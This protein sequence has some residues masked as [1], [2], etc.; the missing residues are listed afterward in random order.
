MTQEEAD[1]LRMLIEKTI[2]THALLDEARYSDTKASE[3][4]RE[5]INSLITRPK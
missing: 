5:Y 3:E 4:L 1:K 2:R